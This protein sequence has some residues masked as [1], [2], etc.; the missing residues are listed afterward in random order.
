MSPNSLPLY[1]EVGEGASIDACLGINVSS[2]IMT[3][4]VMIDDFL[5]EI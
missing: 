1:F 4:P 5:N 2:L 3:K